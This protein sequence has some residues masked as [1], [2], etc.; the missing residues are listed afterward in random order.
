ML[1]IKL[2]RV[3]WAILLAIA[4]A[5]PISAMASE[6]AVEMGMGGLAP[7]F[8]PEWIGVWVFAIAGGVS[9]S[10]IQS[11]EMDRY[12]RFSPTIV[13]IVMGTF[14]GMA[15]SSA[16]G[17]LSDTPLGAISLFAFIASIVM[18]LICIGFMVY[19]GSQ[20]RQNEVY[21]MGRDMLTGRVFGR[22]S[23]DGN[24]NESS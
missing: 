12:L 7:P 23:K 8:T 17:T 21:D 18:A 19:V 16:I 24:D 11:E 20:K 13:K 4:L 15:V 1:K 5:Y 3:W 10:F 14:G 2:G 6:V 9:A 22:K